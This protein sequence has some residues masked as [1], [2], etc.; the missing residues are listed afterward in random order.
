[1]NKKFREMIVEI[2]VD[3]YSVKHLID[4]GLT[5]EELM[6][7][8]PEFSTDLLEKPSNIYTNVTWLPMS[9]DTNLR[10][11]Y[12]R[13]LIN[14][15]SDV[16]IFEKDLATI[17]RS[18]IL[19]VLM[20]ETVRPGSWVIQVPIKGLKKSMSIQQRD[21]FIVDTLGLSI[22]IVEILDI[23]NQSDND[24]TYTTVIFLL[25][26]YDAN[27]VVKECNRLNREARDDG[28][29]KYVYVS[30]GLREEN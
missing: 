8:I 28:P 12:F 30:G 27:R 24:E 4:T 7:R 1:M 3:Q 15:P 9:V 17:R 19:K 11:T 23:R 21:R 26:D 20:I 2:E 22:P 18:H 25:E 10:R 16:Q 6:K 5:K 29:Y 13:V 14:E